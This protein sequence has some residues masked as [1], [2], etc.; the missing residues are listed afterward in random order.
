VRRRPVR[1][2]RVGPYHIIGHDVVLPP[3][4]AAVGRPGGGV[5]GW[6]RGGGG[7]GDLIGRG[8]ALA[9]G[10]EDRGPLALAERLRAAGG[11][12]RGGAG[13]GVGGREAGGFPPR[14]AGPAEPLAGVGAAR[15][16]D[17]L[18]HRPVGRAPRRPGPDRRVRGRRRPTGLAA[19][20]REAFRGEVLTAR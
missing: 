8:R 20:R 9:Q 3:V 6:R 13:G 15:R 10:A 19:G 4:T 2:R 12:G 18:G 16:A 11:G 17:V 1:R 7:G 14:R 5:V